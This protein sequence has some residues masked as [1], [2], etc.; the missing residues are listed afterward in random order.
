MGSGI[1][2]SKRQVDAIVERH[3]VQTDFNNYLS[4]MN[5]YMDGWTIHEDFSVEEKYWK[6]IKKINRL[7]YREYK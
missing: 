5:P 7:I 3:R 2:L 6:E 4:N 1:S